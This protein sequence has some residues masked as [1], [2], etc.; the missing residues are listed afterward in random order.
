[1]Q[2]KESAHTLHIILEDGEIN[3]DATPEERFDRLTRI[4]KHTFNVP[5]ALICL[6]ESKQRLW[7]KSYQGLS[8]QDI[9]IS[10]QSF[11]HVALSNRD[12][13][14]YIPDTLSNDCFC[15]HACVNS[16][17]NIRF[18]TGV[19]IILGRQRI[20]TLSIIDYQP[21]TLTADQL[22]IL[23]DLAHCVEAEFK[24]IQQKQLIQQFRNQ[25]KY[26][27]TM[28]DTIVDGII[29]I[30][31][32]G[33]IQTVNEATLSIFGYRAE[34][35]IGNNVSMLMPEPFHSAHDSY[36][37][38]YLSTKD[39][40]V[41][42]T[43]RE[44]VGLRRNGNKFPMNLAIG[45][46]EY[47][48]EQHFVGI[49]REITEQKKVQ[50]A[51]EE[52]KYVLD[53]TADCVFL[54][55]I[56]TLRFTYL[57]DGIKRQLGYNE[58]E[59]LAMEIMDI[60][61]EFDSEHYRHLITSLLNEDKPSLT[62]ET[63]HR[64]KDG[65]DIPVEMTLQVIKQTEKRPR[66]LAIVRDISE[67]KAVERMK[68]QFV[69]TVSHEL[70]TPLTS[71]RGALGL[72]LGGALGEIPEKA[73]PM[74]TMATR[75]SERLT[76]LI[77]DLLDLEKIESEQMAFTFES[78]DLVQVIRQSL[79]SNRGYA[80]SY[81]VTLQ[82][83]TSVEQ[84]WIHADEHRL[85]QVLANLLSN[86]IK[87]SRQGGMVH[88]LIVQQ[89]SNYKVLIQ[90]QG[91]GIPEAFHARIFGR[92][93]QADGADNRQKGGSGLGLSISKA[94]IERHQG[95]IG[96]DS[97]ESAGT[98]F[99][100]TLPVKETRNTTTD[101]CLM[102]ASPLKNDRQ[103]YC[104]LL[105]KN[106]VEATDNLIKLLEQ[107]GFSYALTSNIAEARVLL[108]Q[109]KYTLMVVNISLPEFNSM[110]FIH[111][112]RS[113]PNADELNI[114]I[115]SLADENAQSEVAS[116]KYLHQTIP[117][118]Q[119]HNALQLALSGHRR[120]KILHVEDDLDII[121]LVKSILS[122]ETMNYHSATSLAEARLFLA[123]QTVDLVILDLLLPDGS[124]MALLPELKDRCRII[125]FSCHD[126]SDMLNKQVSAL[127]IK[128]TT[129]NEQL[130]TTIRR[131]LNTH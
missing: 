3:I 13:L 15:D 120:A 128:S 32:R 38:N 62:I 114:I 17:Q 58:A 51:L 8:T 82:L 28:L 66:L 27:N 130:L 1:M 42:G 85:L 57:N 16:M 83:H 33:I 106:N 69:S 50:R 45:V 100:F 103:S 56:D 44:V 14:L 89:E 24:Q 77:N 7:L 75:N 122:K 11:C 102:T 74:L 46:M 119:L 10:E 104:I 52:F 88:L 35:M 67:R 105:C 18:Y 36:L 112:L 40:K 78:I 30:N 70:R 110:A 63:V 123:T 54:C 20:G 9:I 131:V 111:E 31:K 34:E 76:L 96:F 113:L 68:S 71:I 95:S 98:T 37:S 65:H 94:I 64:H 127:L 116:T 2:P 72:I 118:D 109:Q 124:G 79:E 39:A 23:R 90:D 108:S 87:F 25:K 53:H 26:L 91:D 129:D 61:P 101:V 5:I 81:A 29:T 93:A 99:F 125:V 47:S 12:D 107:E 97:V 92:F 115:T 86:A 43:G 49:V 4:A 121:E 21:H 22:A 117:Y 41:I 59:L 80:E 126:M 19:P 84:A 60:N 55:R 73:R 6:K 48:K